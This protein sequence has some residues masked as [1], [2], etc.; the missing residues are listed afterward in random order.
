MTQ[1]TTNLTSQTIVLD[2]SGDVVEELK[3]QTTRAS[4]ESAFGSR[5]SSR[6]A[7][8]VGTHSAWIAELLTSYGHEVIVANPRKVHLIARG[9]RKSDR[10][11]AEALARLARRQEREEAGGCGYGTEADVD[12]VR[13]LED[14]DGFRASAW[15]TPEGVHGGCLTA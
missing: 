13:S 9:R 12:P 7:L 11:D 1:N 3:L 6:I 15:R 5:P 8:E 10:N 4:L 2:P 14:A